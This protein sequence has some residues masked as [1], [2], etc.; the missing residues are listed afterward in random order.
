MTK[1][2]RIFAIIIGMMMVLGT[3]ISTQAQEEAESQGTFRFQTTEGVVQ[4]LAADISLL[5]DKVWEIK[6]EPFCADYYTEVRTE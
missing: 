6:Q 1:A 4:I 5:R 3:A 2:G